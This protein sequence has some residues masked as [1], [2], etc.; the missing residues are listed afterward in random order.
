MFTFVSPSIRMSGKSINLEDKKVD[1]RNF[2][3]KK[4]YLR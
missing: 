2:Y 4:T 1:K 3:K